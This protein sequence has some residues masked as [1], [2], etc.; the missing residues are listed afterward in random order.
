MGRRRAGRDGERLERHRELERGG[1]PAIGRQ[2][3][4][5]VGRGLVL[6]R[7]ELLFGTHK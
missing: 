3:G 7:P 4:R 5:L 1:D 6:L 2:N